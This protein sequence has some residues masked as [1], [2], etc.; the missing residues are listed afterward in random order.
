VGQLGSRTGTS[1][2]A[3]EP[4]FYQSCDKRQ[5]LTK[6]PSGGS[7][8]CGEDKRKRTQPIHNEPNAIKVFARKVAHQRAISQ[9]DAIFAER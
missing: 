1:A 5:C 4:K 6:Y 7:E 3:I 2:A 9:A 8:F